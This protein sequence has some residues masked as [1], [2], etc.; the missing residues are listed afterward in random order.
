MTAGLLVHRAMLPPSSLHSSP[1]KRRFGSRP[2]PFSAGVSADVHE[3][4]S[5]RSCVLDTIRALVAASHRPPSLSASEASPRG[6]APSPK[7]VE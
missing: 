2:T 4:A 3:A 7:H 6:G 5:L 1:Y